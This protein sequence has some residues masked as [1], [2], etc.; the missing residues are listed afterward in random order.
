MMAPDR[1]EP[2]KDRLQREVAADGA[3]SYHSYVKPALLP[4]LLVYVGFAALNSSHTVQLVSQAGG[5]DSSPPDAHFRH[6]AR[7]SGLAMELKSPLPTGLLRVHSWAAIAMFVLTFV[8]K[9]R[10]GGLVA[11]GVGPNGI[12]SGNHS[13]FV[14]APRQRPRVAR[15]PVFCLRFFFWGSCN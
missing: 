1:E 5:A 6:V 12:A 7:D 13:P 11:G 2:A 14:P 9:E 15:L 3:D 8:Q 10:V 4:V